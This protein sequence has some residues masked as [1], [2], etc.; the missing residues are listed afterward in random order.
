MCI[1]SSFFKSINP[2]NDAIYL[3]L[4]FG[5]LD[6]ENPLLLL[7]GYFSR[8]CHVLLTTR[9]KE[10]TDHFYSRPG[11]FDKLLRLSHDANIANVIMMFLNLLST[12]LD[13]QYDD[14]RIVRVDCVRKVLGCIEQLKDMADG[15]VVENLCRVL[16]ETTE[17]YYLIADGKELL[18]VI[19][20]EKTISQLFVLSQNPNTLI[21]LPI[22][23]LLV[24]LIDYYAFSSL[25]SE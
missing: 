20:N 19:L 18:D 21:S 11:L 10:L 24:S 6:Q 8:V 12:K 15:L 2:S 14:R 4:L 13:R 25:N 5:I 9:Y 23:T 22:V 16:T 1:V 17:K 7:T 3:D